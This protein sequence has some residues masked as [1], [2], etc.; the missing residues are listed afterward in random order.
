MPKCMETTQGMRCGDHKNIANISAGTDFWA[1][2]GWE[3]FAQL[4]EFYIPLSLQPFLT[5]YIY[6]V[7]PLLTHLIGSKD[8]RVSRKPCKSNNDTFFDIHVPFNFYL[9]LEIHNK[10]KFCEELIAYVPS[11][12]HGPHRKRHLQQFFFVAGTSLR[13]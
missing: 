7:S 9:K 6:K 12:R 2:V 1:Y 11:I 3:F 10:K 4:I 5:L 8:F 13:S